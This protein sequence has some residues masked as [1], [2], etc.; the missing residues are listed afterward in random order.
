MAITALVAGVASF[1]ALMALL[2]VAEYYWCSMRNPCG[3]E[4]DAYFYGIPVNNWTLAIIVIA[5]QACVMRSWSFWPAFKRLA[6]VLAVVAWLAIC[7]PFSYDFGYLI[8]WIASALACYVVMG[9][10]DNIA[11]R[12]MDRSA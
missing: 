5:V 4:M 1:G 10:G 9:M 7:L 6:I 2:P 8:L 12:R 3:H 11:R